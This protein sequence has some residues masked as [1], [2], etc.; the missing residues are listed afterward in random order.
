M[1]LKSGTY[2]VDRSLDWQYSYVFFGE[3]EFSIPIDLEVG[4]HGN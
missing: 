3:K 4:S 1:S 2:N